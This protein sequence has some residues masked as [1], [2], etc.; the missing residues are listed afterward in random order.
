[1]ELIIKII[2]MVLYVIAAAGRAP[3]AKKVKE[4]KTIKKIKR[5]REYFLLG[6]G[7]IMMILPLF[8]IFSDKLNNFNMNLPLPIRI[9][10]GIFFLIAVFL[11]NY[12][13]FLLKTNWAPTVE[14][15]E[16][17]KLITKG[18]YKYIRHPMYLAFFIWVVSQGI[19][20]SNWLI[21]VVGILMHAI[22][23]K[24][25]VDD[26]EKMMLKQFKNYKSYMKK[27]GRLL[28]KI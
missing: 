2:Y 8:Y 7:A 22:V 26:E 24:S 11:H 16:N 10:G 12:T 14:I 28:P 23:Y 19:F 6:F 18:I 9:I 5:K 15:K 4:I 27:T 21:L 3:Y 25:R 20:L 1:M 13:H 17:Q